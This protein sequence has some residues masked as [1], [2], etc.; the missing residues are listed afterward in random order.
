ME[1]LAKEQESCLLDCE[2]DNQVLVAKESIPKIELPFEVAEDEEYYIEQ[3]G[4]IKKKPIF[5]FFKRTFDFFV[6]LVCL[7]IL[8]VPFIIIAIAIK[9]SSKGPVFY[10]QERLGLN[11]KK[12]NLIKFRS[13]VA[14]AEKDGARWSGGDGD[15]RI[16]KVG[17][18]LRKTRIDELPQLLNCLV[19]N[20]TIVGPR[21]ERECFYNAFE[22]YIHGFSERLKVKP[23]ITGLAQVN[24]GYDLKPQ[25]KVLYDI[26]YIKKRSL[27]LDIKILFKTVGIVFSH[28]GA[29]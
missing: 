10:K 28:D 17:R 11:G 21:P 23:G 2:N 9:C 15:S 1:E 24:G 7:I 13:M 5:S 22:T 6:S 16:T 3:L 19:G 27:W 14:D 26:E 8:I 29:K 4:K 20:M 25:E 18:F 12:F